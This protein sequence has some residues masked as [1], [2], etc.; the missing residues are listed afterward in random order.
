MFFLI[1]GITRFGVR[2]EW[3]SSTTT[4]FP[5]FKGFGT[6]DSRED[7]V[8]I[9]DKVPTH[10]NSSVVF[11]FPIGEKMYTFILYSKSLSSNLKCRSR[12]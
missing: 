6:H 2:I 11:M 9:F 1:P 7:I 4:L 8:A 10:A 12:N 5:T 3:T